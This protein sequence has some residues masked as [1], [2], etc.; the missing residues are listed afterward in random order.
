MSIRRKL[1]ILL[2]LISLIPLTGIVLFNRYTF[3]IVG[4]QVT[5]DIRILLRNNA[6]YNM[7]DVIR[8]FDH[9][10]KSNIEMMRLILE[11]QAKEIENSM[12]DQGKLRLDLEGSTFG[13]DN[14]LAEIN[15]EPNNYFRRDIN[16][17]KIPLPVSFKRQNFFI[18]RGFSK[19][20]AYKVLKKLVPMTEK[21]HR[22]FLMKPEIIFWMHVTFLNGLHT[23]YPGGSPIPPDYNPFERGWFTGAENNKG[24]YSSYPYID[25][26]SKHPVITISQPFYR[27]NGSFA[28]VVGL[29]LDLNNIFDW[30]H[31][32]PEWGSGAEAILLSKEEDQNSGDLKILAQMNYQPGRMEWNEPIELKSITSSDTSEFGLFKKD[33]FSGESGVRLLSFNGELSI[34]SYRGFR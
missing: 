33:V 19:N 1:L 8:D 7:Q 17:E 15:P 20:S 26:S 3:E 28:G 18:T 9:R 4:D 2:L 10:L 23:T 13:F 21:Y 31:I 12:R 24:F 22:L 16:G 29:D 5:E 34:W 30:M 25:A 11:L 14:R 27:D 32:N 6:I